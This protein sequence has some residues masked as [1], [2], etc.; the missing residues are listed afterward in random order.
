MSQ[1][2]IEKDV[3]FPA[4]VQLPPLPL[5]DMLINDS[6]KVNVT[7]G[8]ETASLSQ[9]LQRF[10]KMNHPKRFSIRRINQDTVR[11]FRREDFTKQ[12]MLRKML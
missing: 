8:S 2:K 11:V 5:D 1:V 7:S 10:Q 4:R 12:D 9:R 6:F 3:P